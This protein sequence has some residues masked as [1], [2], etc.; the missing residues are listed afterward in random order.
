M[1]HKRKE[2][3]MRKQV[4]SLI[5]SYLKIPALAEVTVSH[6]DH[7]IPAKT[8]TAIY[9]MHKFW[10]RKPHNVVR[11]YIEHYSSEGDIVLDPFCGSGVT[12][13]E[14]LK[15]GRKAIATDLDPTSSFITTMTAMPIELKSFAQAFKDIEKKVRKKIDS[16]YQTTCS[17]CRRSV[18]IE[19][20]IWQKNEPIDIILISTISRSQ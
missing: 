5:S 11:E 20:T 12:A 13:I 9:L 4:K 2:Q 3:T 8:H 19:A 17:K 6:I 14:A 10:A 1:L 15:A 16:L 7:A 18:I